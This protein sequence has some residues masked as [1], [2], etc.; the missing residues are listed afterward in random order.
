MED[1][2]ASA[3]EFMGT[4]LIC[5]LLGTGAYFTVR[6]GFLQFRHFGHMFSIF[7]HSRKSDEAGISPFQALCTSL[8]ARVG[9]GNLAGVAIA[10]YLGGPGAVFGCG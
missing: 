7:K 6:L 2:I 1:L 8:A 4:I 5:L 10:V 3:N 9:T